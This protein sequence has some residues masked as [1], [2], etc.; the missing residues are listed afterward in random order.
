MKIL[1][2]A[3]IISGFIYEDPVDGLPAITHCGEALCCRGH[4]LKPHSHH[5]FEFLYLSRGSAVWKI[6]ETLFSQSMGDLFITFPKEVHSTEP[7][8]NPENHHLWV[9]L[10]LEKLG[11]QGRR[12]ARLLKMRGCHLLPQ[13]HELEF[14]LRGFMSQVMTLRARRKEVILG[15][16]ETFMLLVEQKISMLNEK[17]ESKRVLPYSYS[18]QKA[19]H[20]MRQNLDRRLPL[21]DVAASATVGNISHFCTDFHREVG[22][23]PAAYHLQLR[24]DAAR[25]ALK[26]SDFNVTMAAHQFGFSSSQ[27]FSTQ[28]RRAYGTTP[29][30]WQRQSASKT[31]RV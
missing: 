28:F 29:R 14:I 23:S 27:H 10:D 1:K 12:L 9:G 2:E 30:E 16:L 8:G 19:L 11:E 4:Y 7:K 22:V 20:F 5:G 15:Y 21:K 17:V 25:A 3:Q 18:I 26:E 31:T 6:K 24:L 13:S